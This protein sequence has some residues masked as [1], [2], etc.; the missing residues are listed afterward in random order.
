MDFGH[1]FSFACH[2]SSP[3]LYYCHLKLEEASL[4]LGSGKLYFVSFLWVALQYVLSCNTFWPIQYFEELTCAVMI[5]GI[6]SA[7]A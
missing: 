3:V 1:P 6:L 7:K 4:D 2:S 5:C